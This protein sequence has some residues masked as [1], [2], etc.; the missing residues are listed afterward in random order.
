MPGRGGAER[1]NLRYDRPRHVCTLQ[2][3]RHRTSPPPRA[4]PAEFL[5]SSYLYLPSLTPRS[6]YCHHP[7]G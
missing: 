2:G 7:C 4:T 6:Q 3:P 1:G 5:K